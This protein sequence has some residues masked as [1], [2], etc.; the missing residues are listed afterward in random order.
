[1]GQNAAVKVHRLSPR[2]LTFKILGSLWQF[3][4]GELTT[5]GVEMSARSATV[6]PAQ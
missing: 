1:M 2:I 4:R 3:Y 6:Y 5:K